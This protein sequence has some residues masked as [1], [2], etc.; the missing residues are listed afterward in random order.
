[1]KII[2]K[3]LLLFLLL[4]NSCA[5]YSSDNRASKIE[6][7]YYNSKGFALIYDDDLYKSGVVSKKLKD[8]VNYVMHSTLKRNTPVR[9][10]NPENL[11]FVEAKI[12]KKADYPGIFNIVIS[13]QIAKT[14]N[15]DLDNP[16]TEVLEIK[17][18]KT[19][20]AKKANTFEEESKVA[21]TAPV[22]EI[23][24]NNLN[25]TKSTK[26]DD[27]KK[28]DNN[29]TLIVSDFYYLDSANNLQKE[30]NKKIKNGK[31]LI[32]KINDNKYRLS[33]GPFKNFNA[34]KSTYIS[35]NNLGFEDLNIYKE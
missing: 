2:T 6:K 25:T 31:F 10:I 11:K 3:L 16:Y 29:Y 5:E 28:K 19:F 23:K 35:L 24:M 17:K 21:E 7:Q 13:K 1:M 4:I 27:L 33:A 9:I 32:K 12:F 26:S 20:I 8:E 14:L 15:L 34:L 22:D 30:L 18:N